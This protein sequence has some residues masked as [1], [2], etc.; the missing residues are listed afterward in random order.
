MLLKPLASG[1]DV[2]AEISGIASSSAVKRVVR[3]SSNVCV[4][5]GGGTVRDARVEN[6]RQ[7]NVTTAV[8]GWVAFHVRFGVTETT[9]GREETMV[10][11]SGRTHRSRRLPSL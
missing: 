10:N 1:S 9:S 4:G 11:A 5:G 6:P 7:D 2:G 8:P 3:Q